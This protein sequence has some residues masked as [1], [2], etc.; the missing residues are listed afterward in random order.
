MSIETQKGKNY[1]DFINI[2]VEILPELKFYVPEIIV[3]EYSNDGETIRE[4]KLIE[5]WKGAIS[6]GWHKS[7][8]FETIL[9]IWVWCKKNKGYKIM[10]QKIIGQLMFHRIKASCRKIEK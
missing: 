7:F 4:D 10:F 6:A 8:S 3:K 2:C 9:A 5:F 1:H